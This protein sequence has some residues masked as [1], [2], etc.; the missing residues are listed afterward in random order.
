LTSFANIGHLHCQQELKIQK[1]LSQIQFI[2]R[3]QKKSKAFTKNLEFSMFFCFCYF[4]NLL[5][6]ES[7]VRSLW[8]AGTCS[9][10][11]GSVDLGTAHVAAD[12]VVADQFLRT[13][14]FEYF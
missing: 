9:S 13:N 3:L 11:G 4:E 14:S 10:G 6:A 5:F 7:I 1:F 8:T 2:F 12:A